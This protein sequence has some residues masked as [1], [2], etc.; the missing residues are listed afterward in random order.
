MQTIP[1]QGSSQLPPHEQ[2]G[3]RLIRVYLNVDYDY[4]ENRVGALSAHVTASS[5]QIN[6]GWIETGRQRPDG[7]PEWQPDPVV[8]EVRQ[9]QANPERRP[10]ESKARSWDVM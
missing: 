8:H 7:R 3:E 10:K 4:T 1:E 5:G 9:Q 2:D 6:T